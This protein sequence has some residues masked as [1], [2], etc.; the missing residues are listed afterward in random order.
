MKLIIKNGRVIS[1]A[2]NIDKICDILISDGIIEEID[3]NISP[4]GAK[5]IDADGLCV[6]AG[7]TDLLA[8][9]TEPE[10]DRIESLLTLSHAAVKGGFTTL[11]VHTQADSE[12]KL[13]YIT[14]RAEYAS[15]AIIPAAFATDGKEL[16]AHGLFKHAG[17]GALYDDA[18]ICDPLLMRDALFRA[19][20]NNLPFMV[21]CSEPALCQDGLARA[22]VM[23]ELMDIPTIPSSAETVMIA[24]DIALAI[25]T[26]SPV[27][28]AQVSTAASV[29][30]IRRA[31]ATG[32]KV[33][34]STQP[35]YISL[36]SRELMG[37][38]TLA[39]LDPPLGNPSD[40]Q[41]IIEG[42]ADGTIDC[43]CSDHA[44]VPD[45]LKRKSLVTAPYG[46]SSVELCFSAALT[47]LYKNAGLSLSKVLDTLTAKPASI[48][49]IDSGRIAVGK[50]ADL[51][52]FDP[53]YS[54]IAGGKHLISMGRNTPFDGKELFGLV[55]Y[56]IKDGRIVWQTGK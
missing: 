23:A 12:D 22:G 37:Y 43:I 31:K 52:I 47:A 21:R 6:S 13:D 11:C 18:P 3:E 33:T 38:N 8:R 27:H 41:A 44:P 39:K 7:F 50:I 20:K 24:R 10:L 48:L 16:T 25:D 19:R 35:H 42:I 5:V 28:I 56:T 34:A 30:L 45:E 29:D 9:A 2:D 4:N 32:A 14:E 17:A 49:G 53:D 15:C 46:A 40:I 51:C 54:Y 55:L 26:G 36:S 1:L